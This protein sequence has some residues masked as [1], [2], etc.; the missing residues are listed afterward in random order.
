MHIDQGKGSDNEENQHAERCG[1]LIPVRPCRH[2][3]GSAGQNIRISRKLIVHPRGAALRYHVD[4][5]KVIKVRGKRR[6][7]ERHGEP[8]HHR[9]SDLLEALETRRP[10]YSGRLVILRRDRL[11]AAQTDVH[12]VRKAQPY[13]DDDNARARPESVGQPRDILCIAQKVQQIVDPAVLLVQQSLPRQNGNGGG[14][15]P[16]QD[17]NGPVELCF[18]HMRII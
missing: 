15:G 2:F 13:I 12:H 4:I 8:R 9:Q 10:V 16:W 11:Q 6:D 5:A 17:Q 18:P 3:V 14:K 7:H 1:E